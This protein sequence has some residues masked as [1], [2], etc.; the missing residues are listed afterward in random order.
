MISLA[1]TTLL[2]SAD[3]L[4]LD[5]LTEPPVMETGVS[6]FCESDADCR[7]FPDYPLCHPKFLECVECIDDSHCDP[8]WTCDVGGRCYDSCVTD[9]D[10]D[11][12]GG[13]DTCDTE[14]GICV[15]C[16]DDTHCE[17]AE[18]C[19]DQICM[20]DHCTPGELLCFESTLLE[21]LDNG[22][23]TNVVEECE[24]GCE[25]TERGGVCVSDGSNDSGPGP[26]T[27]GATSGSP[28]TSG[29]ATAGTAP[30]DGTSD[31]TTPADEIP[32]GDGCACNTTTPT[33]MGVGAWLLLLGLRRRRRS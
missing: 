11:G 12:I 28:M 13:F 16:L 3:P 29:S 14:F 15:G 6:M 23:S 8:G 20:P 19:L 27:S 4:P 31:P 5:D 18:Y 10:C 1:L 2:L 22:G 7:I 32:V 26:A 25:M 17:E 30:A 24:L 21:C 9:A 33:P